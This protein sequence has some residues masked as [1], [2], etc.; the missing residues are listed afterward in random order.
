MDIGDLHTKGSMITPLR[1][2]IH[3]IHQQVKNIMDLYRSDMTQKPFVF[4]SQKTGNTFTLES[5]AYPGWFISTSS[6]MGEPVK[7][8]TDL[9]SKNNTDF[10]LRNI[11]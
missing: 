9:G 11:Q 8:T 3:D 10:Y 1:N 7:M 4:Y 2:G 5:A 6:K